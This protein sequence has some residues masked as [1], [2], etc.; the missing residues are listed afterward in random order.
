MKAQFISIV[1]AVLVVCAT[2]SAT[3]TIHVAPANTHNFVQT[4]SL[5]QPFL[6]LEAARDYLRSPQSNKNSTRI[7]QISGTHYLTQTFALDARDSGTATYP[8]TYQGDANTSLFGGIEIPAS[9]FQPVLGKPNVYVAN[10]LSIPELNRTSLGSLGNPYPKAKMELFYGTQQQPMTLARDPNIG[11]DVQKTWKWVG[12]ENMTGLLSPNATHAFGFDDANTATKWM[13]SMSMDKQRNE[14]ESMWLHGYFKFDWRDTYVRV[15]SIAPSAANSSLFTVTTDAATPPQYPYQKGT[16]FYAVN[17]LGLLDA[18][19][20]YYISSATGQLYFY[21][22]SH[23][24]G[25][26]ER[27]VVSVLK[28]VV[29]LTNAKH[30]TFEKLIMSTSQNEVVTIHDSEA[31]ELT[32]S[33]ISNAGNN[34]IL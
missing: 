21:P 34:L 18:P 2:S 3:T 13:N 5:Q 1:S 27:V 22:P 17:S 8:I 14:T 9:S 12:Y 10:L 32:T 30:V 24:A 19:G 28:Q 6:S 7:V 26:T 4:G 15:S 11:D 29:T 20:E 16:R 33:T 25:V 23:G 31:I